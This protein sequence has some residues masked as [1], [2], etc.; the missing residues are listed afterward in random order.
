M[1]LERLQLRDGARLQRPRQHHGF[2]RI[3]PALRHATRLLLECGARKRLL[4]LVSDG[5]PSDLD[6]YERR[7]GVADVAPRG[8]RRRAAWLRMFAPVSNRNTVPLA[9]GSGERGGFGV[10]LGWVGVRGPT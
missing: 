9:L 2:T 5:K 7:Y 6:R 8:G 1:G 3:G 10:G 4:L